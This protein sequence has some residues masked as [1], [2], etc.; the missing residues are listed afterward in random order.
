MSAPTFAAQV[1]R[2]RLGGLVFLGVLM[3]AAAA[4]VALHPDFDHRPVARIA[5]W[6]GMIF[7]PL[8]IVIALR[9]FFRTGPVM[10]IGP[11]GLCWRRWSDQT[12]PWHAFV[13]AEAV[14]V[15][16][17]KMLS[18]WLRDPQAWRSTRLLGRL[19]GANKA[20]GF[21]DITLT[22]QGT[23]RSFE[24][25]AGAVHDHAPHLFG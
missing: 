19:A 20:L 10:E 21:G 13:R 6:V 18:L 15:N 1:S 3:T 24:E 8:C 11:E 17:Q 25:M 9:Q 14:A 22:A 5:G 4:F 7:F 16:R 23:D 12:I 2:L